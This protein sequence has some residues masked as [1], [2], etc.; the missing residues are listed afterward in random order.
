M[1][2]ATILSKYNV[3]TIQ[4]SGRLGYRKFGVASSG[5]MDKSLAD[6]TNKILGNDENA[7]VLEIFNSTFKLKFSNL[8]SI[9]VSPNISDF[10]L[11]DVHIENQCQSI[12]ISTNDILTIS[13]QNVSNWFYIAVKGGWQTEEVLGSRCTNTH[14]S[15]SPLSYMSILNYNS[16]DSFVQSKKTSFPL[17]D[18]ENFDIRIKKSKTY[19]Q[20]QK[21]LGKIQFEKFALSSKSNRH[22]YMLTQK[23]IVDTF[24]YFESESTGVFP[25]CVQLTPSGHAYVLMMDCQTT[26]G[27]PVIGVIDEDLSKL[28][29][30]KIEEKVINFIFY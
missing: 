24:Q 9:S 16:S 14:L 6:F 11:N 8:C 15:M 3:C 10:T 23:F 12:S 25:G 13:R 7:A 5:P 4:D 30:I 19:F 2:S 20:Y 22:A 26:G 29:Q 1:N 18:Y 28:S 27:Y 21:Y 17:S